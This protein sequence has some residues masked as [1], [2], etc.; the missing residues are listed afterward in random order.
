MTSGRQKPANRQIVSGADAFV[1]RTVLR[2]I[3][4]QGLRSVC[5]YG[6]GDGDLLK[7]IDRKTEQRLR[8]T[9]IDYF[10]RD[11]RWR[12]EWALPA[13]SPSRNLTFVDR[14][15]RALR[16]LTDMGG[17]FELVTS[18]CALHHFQY[19]CA[20]LQSIR[21]L[22]R[23]GGFVL[24]ADWD[25]EGATAPGATKNLFSFLS[26]SFHAFAGKYHRHHYTLEQAQD[27]FLATGL[28]VVRAETVRF[29]NPTRVKERSR[30]N[31]LHSMGHMIK[32]NSTTPDPVVKRYFEKEFALVR[33]LVNK[34]G[35]D[36]PSMYLLIA[37][38][39]R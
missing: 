19:P 3:K 17:A 14:E 4:H 35:I 16:R 34:Y 22:T 5:D 28:K 7:R 1:E 11:K 38:K 27:L 10:S 15:S 30:E 6:C 33:P 36:Y 2:L 39:H 8:L 23:P 18:I 31:A 29:R 20:E 12:K 26:E 25:F 37:Q 32:A 24:L 21:S 9:G 13:A